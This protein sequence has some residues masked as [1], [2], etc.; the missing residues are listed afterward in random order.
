M[1]FVW[2]FYGCIYDLLWELFWD[3]QWVMVIQ[4][5]LHDFFK[6]LSGCCSI[7]WFVHVGLLRF[8]LCKHLKILFMNSF[9]FQSACAILT[10]RYNCLYTFLV[11]FVFWNTVAVCIWFVS[12]HNKSEWC[13]S[14]VYTCN[15]SLFMSKLID[16]QTRHLA[17]SC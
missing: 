8:M 9:L 15:A 2:L 6:L 3:L 5:I 7:E 12:S 4:L 17:M 16:H 11:A 14:C 10:L 1:K 13:C